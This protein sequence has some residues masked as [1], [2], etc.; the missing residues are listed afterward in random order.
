MSQR[1]GTVGD[2]A[3]ANVCSCSCTFMC[4]AR[5]QDSLDAFL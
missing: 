5:K 4:T 1:K 2:S 3:L